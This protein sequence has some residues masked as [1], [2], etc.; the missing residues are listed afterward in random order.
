[1][2][3]FLVYR[4]ALRPVVSSWGATEAEVAGAMSGD[5]IAP[6]IS[7]TR[8]ITIDGPA[9]DVWLW[10]IQLGADR[11]GFYSYS[12]LESVFGYTPRETSEIRP[13]FTDMDVGRVV[14]ASLNDSADGFD[15]NFT[16]LAVDPGKSVVLENWGTLEVRPISESRCRLLARTNGPS[17]SGAGRFIFES[18]VAPPHHIMERRMLL[19][20]KARAEAGAG[21][22]LSTA[23]DNLWLLGL[24]LSAAGIVT[25]VWLSS[26]T[27]WS[28]VSI[29]L[30][31]AWLWPLLV[32]DPIPVY[33]LGF[34][35]IVGVVLTWSL[36]LRK[37]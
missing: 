10:L 5:S 22:P 11:G 30:G 28:A 25:L 16:V 8:A 23:S 24:A 2:A 15:F 6:Y 18:F 9:S 21:L 29:V 37:T 19:G 17:S 31:A 13:E 34:L 1:M 14:R 36:R 12:A 32:L 4:I 35:L 33:S 26:G 20:I 7:S 3:Q 27:W